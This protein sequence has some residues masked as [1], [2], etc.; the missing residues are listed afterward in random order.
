MS[1]RDKYYKTGDG[2]LFVFSLTDSSSLED[3]KE[4]F[5]SLLFARVRMSL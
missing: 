2:F 3:V 5:R 4:R 1:M